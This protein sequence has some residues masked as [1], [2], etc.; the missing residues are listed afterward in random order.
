MSL[1]FGVPLSLPDAIITYFIDLKVIGESVSIPY[2]NPIEADSSG[3]IGS[4]ANGV[5]NN[6]MPYITQVAIGKLEKLQVFD[7]D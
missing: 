5:P 2:F 3:Q 6:S 1:K 4:N 7:N